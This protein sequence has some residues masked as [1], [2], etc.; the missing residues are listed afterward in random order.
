MKMD[1]FV[2]YSLLILNYSVNVTTVVVV[3]A[4]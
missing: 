1:I 3:H 2:N 4:K